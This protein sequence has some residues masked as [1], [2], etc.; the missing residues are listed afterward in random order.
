MLHNIEATP[1]FVKRFEAYKDDTISVP[2]F[3]SI[4]GSEEYRERLR[5][6]SIGLHDRLSKT[7][8]EDRHPN[9]PARIKAMEHLIHSLAHVASFPAEKEFVSVSLSRDT[10]SKGNLQHLSFS[11]VSDVVKLLYDQTELPLCTFKRGSWDRVAKV[12]VVSRLKACRSLEDIMLAEGLVWE[13]HPNESKKTKKKAIVY[14]KSNDDKVEIERNTLPE[15]ENIRKLNTMLASIK[16]DITFPDYKAYE[17][18]WDYRTGSSRLFRGNTS[19]YR[20][21]KDDDQSGGRIFGHWCTNCPKDLRRYI[22]FNDQPVSE[23]D[24]R[25]AQVAFAYAMLGE[26]MPEGDPYVIPGYELLDRDIFK[27]CFTVMSGASTSSNSAVS[28][29]L[30]NDGFH[31]EPGSVAGLVEAFW[32]HHE[33]VASFRGSSAWRG[34]QKFESDIALQVIAEMVEAGIPVVPIH[35]G[36]LC[37]ANDAEKL[38]TAMKAAVASLSAMPEVRRLY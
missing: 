18:I 2:L 27:S 38:E 29:K 19:I 1:T 26:T 30:L 34:L 6:F 7:C 24:F 20:Q 28:Q 23:C 17:R 37:P 8:G 15:E 5:K 32:K 10:Y 3:H 11:A 16:T 25:G 31:M 35:D 22:T 13:T 36:F 21:F 33:K 14:L 4:Y 12:G 9:R